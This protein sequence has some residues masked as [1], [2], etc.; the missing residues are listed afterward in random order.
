MGGEVRTFQRNDRRK[1]VCIRTVGMRARSCS[2]DMS[3]EQYRDLQ[4]MLGMK[5]AGKSK[6]DMQLVSIYLLGGIEFRL[7]LQSDDW[8]LEYC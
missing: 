7:F 4:T 3:A 6:K 8:G 5:V 2:G 1:F